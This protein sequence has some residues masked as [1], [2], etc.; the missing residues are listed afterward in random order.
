MRCDRVGAES[1]G[2]SGPGGGGQQGPFCGGTRLKNDESPAM[3][4]SGL[5][6]RREMEDTEGTEFGCAEE[7]KAGHPE[8]GCK[9]QA[10]SRGSCRWRSKGRHSDFQV[11]VFLLLWGVWF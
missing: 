2:V 7:W 4:R 10:A 1:V 8:L 5:R 6:A 3:P 11:F 9:G